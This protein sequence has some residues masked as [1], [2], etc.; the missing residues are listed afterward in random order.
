[1]YYEAGAGI[2]FIVLNQ[3]EVNARI[4]GNDPAAAAYEAAAS[5][6]AT[7]APG[8]N[9]MYVHLRRNI[10]YSY[11]LQVMTFQVELLMQIP[12]SPPFLTTITTVATPTPGAAMRTIMMT[13]QTSMGKI[14]Y[15]Y[16]FLCKNFLVFSFAMIVC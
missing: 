16:Y 12:S 7:H 9:K 10:T 13:L 3:D 6:A 2:G 4:A 11:I 14:V 15:F 8:K 1:M 5:A